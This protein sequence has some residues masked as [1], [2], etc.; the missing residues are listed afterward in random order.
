M[1]R[2]HASNLKDL[3]TTDTPSA[4]TGTTSATTAVSATTGTPSATTGTPSATTGTPSATTG[5]P[6]A[7][8][9]TATTR[10]DRAA[11]LTANALLRKT[12]TKSALRH[13]VRGPK[14]VVD[15]V[16]NAINSRV[17]TVSKQVVEGSVALNGVVRRRVS[18]VENANLC[19]VG[20]DDVF[21]QTFIRQLLV[22]S[23]DAVQPIQ[24]VQVF[25]GRFPMLSPVPER[26]LGDRNIYSDA[27]RGYLTNM[28]T[29]LQ[30]SIDKR[31]RK[32]CNVFASHYQIRGYEK[33][34]MLYAINGWTFAPRANWPA[35]AFPMRR[36][37]FEAIELHRRTLGLTSEA[38]RITKQWL[39]AATS[40]PAM[41]RYNVL[42]NR[43]YESIGAKLFTIVPV[44]HVKRHFIALDTWSLFGVLKE[45]GL[46]GG[47]VDAFYATRDEQWRSVFKIEQLQG[48]HCTFAHSIETDGIALC[49]HFDRPRSGLSS[50]LC[51]DKFRIDKNDVVVGC[52][53]GRIN[54]FFMVV[55]MPDGKLKT[56]VL[57]RRQYYSESGIHNAI[58]QSNAWNNGVK[59]VLATMSAVSIKGV[60]FDAYMAYVDAYRAHRDALWA[61]YLRP[62]WARQRLSLYGGKKRVFARFFNNM[63]AVLDDAYPGQRV[64]VA[65]G[66][67]KFAPGGRNEVSVPTSR[68]YKECAVRFTTVG[69]PEFRTSKVDFI[70]ATHMSAIRAAVPDTVITLQKV[71]VKGSRYALRGTLWSVFLRRFVSRDLNAALNIRRQLIDRPV[72]LDRTQATGR[73]DQRI[74]KRIKPR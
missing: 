15:K 3:A 7:T 56:F 33:V 9:K 8:T 67:A 46:A 37:V 42:L 28:K 45:A 14:D 36:E 17:V 21:D 54:I 71:A 10:P 35:G 29:A 70:T 53:P 62:R 2:E 26:Y 5:T 22:G 72:I 27:A 44:C 30:T 65:Y 23:D 18:Q 32:F 57:T 40:Q 24:A 73:L 48:Q 50:T 19:N 63:K 1:L 74:V 13:Y 20:F 59:D 61:E 12:T 58:K 34:Y 4:T 47:S 49:V 51:F 41:L 25:H 52:D 64:V 66:A 16:V 55:P 11:K 60:A 38:P 39:K 6:S 69:T 31:V 43:F 68:A